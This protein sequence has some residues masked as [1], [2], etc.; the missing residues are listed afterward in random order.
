[1]VNEYLLRLA[2]S[3]I[4]RVRQEFK[5]EV[6]SCQACAARETHISELTDRLQEMSLREQRAHE[7]YKEL[8]ELLLTRFGVRPPTPSVTL[9]TEGATQGHVTR[10][11]RS[12]QVGLAHMAQRTHEKNKEAWEK[13]I[14]KVDAFDRANGI[15]KTGTTSSTPTESQPN[16]EMKP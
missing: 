9:T 11:R 14:D 12:P 6:Q 4:T 2:D 15:V 1:M 8:Q 3:I 7:D 10:E 16:Q 5:K 13:Q